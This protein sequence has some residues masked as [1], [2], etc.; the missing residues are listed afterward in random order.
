MNAFPRF[1][2]AWC[3]IGT[4]IVG[5]FVCASTGCRQY[6]TSTQPTLR[7]EMPQDSSAASARLRLKP[8]MRS[9]TSSMAQDIERSVGY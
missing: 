4:T 2:A 8:G 9:G 3:L 7:D 1:A 6:A 5:A